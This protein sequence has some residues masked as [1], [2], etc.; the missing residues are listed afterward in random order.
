MPSTR[1]SDEGV[2]G[3]LVEVDVAQRLQRGLRGWSLQPDQRRGQ[4]PIVDV[5]RQASVPP[6]RDGVLGVH[7]PIRGVEDEQHL[8]GAPPI[9][10]HV[11]Q[12]AAVFQA[13]QRVGRL[14]VV[15][16]RQ[17]ARGAHLGQP[18]RVASVQ[19]HSTHMR[20]VEQADVAT[21]RAV[22]GQDAGRVLDG[23]VP[24]GE[25]DHARAQPTMRGVERR[26][27]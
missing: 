1:A 5:D 4:R 19:D 9:G 7:D 10:D 15:H 18:H 17:V 11:V 8:L 26:L 6:L 3:E 22:L 21:H 20:Q 13:Q 2:A 27:E 12:D 14:A 23:H 16:A 25:I 24:A